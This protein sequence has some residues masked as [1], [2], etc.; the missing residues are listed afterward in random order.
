MI[1]RKFAGLVLPFI[2]RRI[3][4]HAQTSQD[5]PHI[6]PDEYLFPRAFPRDQIV[7][8]Y[9]T[10]DNVLDVIY[11]TMSPR[12]R[13]LFF[14]Q[15]EEFHNLCERALIRV[16]FER[17]A[18]VVRHTVAML[19]A[20]C[21]DNMASENNK[22][23]GP[24][25]IRY[26]RETGDSFW[27]RDIS[28]PAPAV[29]RSLFVTE[30]ERKALINALDGSHAGRVDASRNME[31]LARAEG[32]VLFVSNAQSVET[33]RRMTG[34]DVT[35]NKLGK[36]LLVPI[37]VSDRV[38]GFVQIGRSEKEEV[39]PVLRPHSALPRQEVWRAFLERGQQLFRPDRKRIGPSYAEALRQAGVVKE[40]DTYSV[41][42]QRKNAVWLKRNSDKDIQE[43]YGRLKEHY[44]ALFDREHPVF[45]SP[46]L[47]LTRSGVSANEVAIRGVSTILGNDK[48]PAFRVPGWYFENNESIER[49]FDENGDPQQSQA[50]FM[51]YEPIAIMFRDPNAYAVARDESPQFLIDLARRNPRRPYFMVVDKTTNLLYETFQQGQTLPENLTFIE[52]ASLTK[53]QRGGRNY[54]FGMVLFWGRT[55][56]FFAMKSQLDLS[57]G[58]L[59][60]L[61]I[62]HFPR[63][64]ER[65]IKRRRAKFRRLGQAV[66]ESSKAHKQANG[67][68]WD[69]E[70][71]DCYAFIIPPMDLLIKDYLQDINKKPDQV[72]RL[73]KDDFV[74]YLKERGLDV[75]GLYDVCYKIGF[76]KGIELGDSFGLDNTRITAIAGGMRSQ[77]T[78]SYFCT[79]RLSYGFNS[80][81]EELQSYTAKL[82]EELDRRTPADFKKTGS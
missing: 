72:T 36:V 21:A 81:E 25:E 13:D 74:R 45:G 2:R 3:G 32:S 68:L 73:E 49:N 27:G 60:D 6:M 14:R 33:L 42:I 8:C 24:A 59:T 19:D 17:A 82:M 1:E 76:P 53:H 5:Q 34:M 22:V 15:R 66:F 39:V 41:H 50:F 40:D 28:I 20:T 31:Q 29:H 63:L 77:N 51:S 48:T 37:K 56:D 64:R 79:L 55:P 16:S 38:G 4:Q 12:R 54:F 67:S 62:I 47:L 69:I 58:N 18:D 65:E 10:V 35:L 7:A 9:R 46:H 43:F 52:T 70:S 30:Q 23:W 57:Q 61:E 71:Y 80:S 26:Y 44:H 75:E 78:E 11:E